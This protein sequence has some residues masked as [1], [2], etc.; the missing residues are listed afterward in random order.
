[1]VQSTFQNIFVMIDL[2]EPLEIDVLNWRYFFEKLKIE[3]DTMKAKGSNVDFFDING[4]D[5][6]EDFFYRN[7]DSQPISPV[8]TKILIDIFGSDYVWSENGFSCWRNRGILASF[9][10][11]NAVG[12]EEIES[13]QSDREFVIRSWHEF[14]ESNVLKP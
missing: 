14:V 3:M 6:L 2:S 5:F 8:F 10:A 11:R 12:D 13:H 4:Y 1:M 9:I 7:P